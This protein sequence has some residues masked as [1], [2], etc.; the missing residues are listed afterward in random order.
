MKLSHVKEKAKQLGI[1]PKKI[2]KADLIREIQ[3]G[4]GY[5]P[6]FQMYGYEC[7]QEDCCWRK[8]C[9]T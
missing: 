1:K 4:E 9:L 3:R 7:E 6:C 5:Q 2:R 8:E